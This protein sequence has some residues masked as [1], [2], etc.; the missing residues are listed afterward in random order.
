MD[1]VMSTGFFP[2]NMEEMNLK[3][4]HTHTQPLRVPQGHHVV[5]QLK[6]SVLPVKNNTILLG[7]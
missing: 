7:S 3:T 5:I 4:K 6:Q 1:H 2:H